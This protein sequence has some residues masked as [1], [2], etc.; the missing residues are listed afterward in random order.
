MLSANFLFPATFGTTSSSVAC[1][2]VVIFIKLR[3]LI[4]YR[5][6]QKVNNCESVNARRGFYHQDLSA[7]CL[8]FSDNDT[9]IFLESTNN[10]QIH[11]FNLVIKLHIISNIIS[12]NQICCQYLNK[13]STTEF[14]QIIVHVLNI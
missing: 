5:Y 8:C 14:F 10:Q 11:Q 3:N 4:K 6:K 7:P 9:F 1:G 2:F 13:I 12:I